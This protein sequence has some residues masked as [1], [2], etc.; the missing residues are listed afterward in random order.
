MAKVSLKQ[1]EIE[2]IKYAPDLVRTAAKDADQHV[3][4]QM[5]LAAL[6]VP[7]AFDYR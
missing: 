4:D 1:D 6:C 3:Y 2:V 5:P 7:V